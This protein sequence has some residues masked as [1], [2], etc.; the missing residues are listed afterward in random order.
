MLS[1]WKRQKLYD[2]KQ[3]ITLFSPCTIVGEGKDQICVNDHRTEA[4][5]FSF[6][7]GGALDSVRGLLDVG[8][9]TAKDGIA[10]GQTNTEGE[11]DE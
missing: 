7:L 3:N 4:S 10:S 8:R 2:C 6:H 9:S 11:G 5:T 1:K